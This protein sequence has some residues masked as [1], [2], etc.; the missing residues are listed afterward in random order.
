M[1]RTL[2]CPYVYLLKTPTFVF[3]A[4][5]SPI[6]QHYELT[7]IQVKS[8]WDQGRDYCFDKY[9]VWLKCKPFELQDLL[10]VKKV[11]WHVNNLQLQILF[12]T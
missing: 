5:S 7:P 2:L 10:G 8:E 4:P 1:F 11:M 12:N 3:A 9:P 6:G